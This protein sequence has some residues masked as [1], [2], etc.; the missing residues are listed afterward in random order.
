VFG[1][2]QFLSVGEGVHP[3]PSSQVRGTSTSTS[4]TLDIVS[5]SS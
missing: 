1:F 5:L 4:P 2:E 3:E